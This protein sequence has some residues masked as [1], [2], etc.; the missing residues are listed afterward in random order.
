LYFS[1]YVHIFSG[2]QSL[3]CYRCL[4][5]ECSEDPA[6][7]SEIRQFALNQFSDFYYMD[8]TLPECPKPDDIQEWTE[9]ETNYPSSV[10]CG[11]LQENEATC[12]LGRFQV[13]LSSVKYYVYVMVMIAV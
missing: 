12:T 2:L 11:A 7:C 4:A 1:L 6:F 10:P 9:M 5:I 13:S 8:S 3:R